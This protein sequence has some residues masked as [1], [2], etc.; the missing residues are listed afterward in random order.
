MIKRC[1]AGLSDAERKAAEEQFSL[2]ADSKWELDIDGTMWDNAGG[3]WSKES[4]FNAKGKW[5][6]AG[7]MIK[8]AVRATKV[9]RFG[10]IDHQK[11]LAAQ[12][13]KAETFGQKLRRLAAARVARLALAAEQVEARQRGMEAAL[14]KK[15]NKAEQVHCLHLRYRLLCSPFHCLTTRPSRF[16]WNSWRGRKR[17]RRPSSRR[18]PRI[19]PR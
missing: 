1:P 18:R 2:E 8:M 15:N 14:R 5:Q 13:M 9:F 16:C 17:R 12:N 7:R 19:A 10:P 6:K 3:V 4:L 11:L